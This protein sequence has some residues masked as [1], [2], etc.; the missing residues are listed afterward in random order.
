MAKRF[1]RD[2]ANQGAVLDAFE[3]Q[4]WPVFIAD[5]LERLAG[6]DAKARLRETV[7]CLNR[8]LAAGTIRFH[9]GGS[10]DGVRWAV[11]A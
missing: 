7:R 2:A 6:L 10:E 3:A 9:S 8:R 5:P 1:R 11:V 4:G